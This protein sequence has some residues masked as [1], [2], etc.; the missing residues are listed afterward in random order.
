MP[1]LYTNMPPLRLENGQDSIVLWM[2][3]QF[4]SA[5]AVEIAVG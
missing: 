2:E 4:K 1:W 3:E 5:D